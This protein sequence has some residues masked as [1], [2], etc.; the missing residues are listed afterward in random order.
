MIE[1]LINLLTTHLGVWIG[2][3]LGSGAAYLAWTFL[4]ATLDRA[5]IGTAL[6]IVGFLTGFAVEVLLHRRQPK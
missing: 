2:G 4:P 5:S 3:V 6:I 1:I